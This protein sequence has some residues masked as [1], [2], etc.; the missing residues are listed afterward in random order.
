[1][2]AINIISWVLN[3]IFWGCIIFF[4]L[5]V[6]YSEILGLIH[7]HY[8][9]IS[10]VNAILISIICVILIFISIGGIILL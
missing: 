10:F 7:N 1:M 2:K 6:I 5:K 9:H 3:F 8:S 4:S